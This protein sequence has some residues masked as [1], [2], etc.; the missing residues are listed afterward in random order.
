M[1]AVAQQSVVQESHT[2]ATLAAE[3]SEAEPGSTV[4]IALKH[5]PKEGWHTYWKNPGDSGIQTII[6]W[7]LSDGSTIGETLYPVPHPLPFGPLTNYGYDAPSILLTPITIPS[8]YQAPTYPVKASI[9]WLICEVECIP[10]FGEFSFDI[11]IGENTIS[12]ENRSIFT[13]ARTKM[14]EPAFW[15]ASLSIAPEAAEL[16]VYMD[17]EETS[18]LSDAY[19]FPDQE[20]ILDYAAPQTFRISEDG[21]VLSLTRLKGSV[22]PEAI[23]GILKL[24]IGD[25]VTAVEVDPERHIVESISNTS[26]APIIHASSLPLWQA[27]LF[28]LIGGLILNLM[29]CVFPVLSLKAFSFLSAGGLSKSERRQEGWSYTFGILASFGAVVGV[30]LLLRAGGSAVG[31]G[32]QLQEPMFVAFMIFVMVL[33]S[34]SLAGMFNIQTGFEGAG[35]AL[36]SQSGNK[37][38]FFTGVLATLVAT[39]CTAPFM[40]PA[41][42]YALSQ[43]F[44]VALTVFFMLGFGLALPFL[45]LSYSE[46]VAR[47]MPRP[48]AWMEKFKKGLAFPML[49]TAA[50]LLWVFSNS[51]GS[52][53]MLLLMLALITIVFAIWLWQQSDG[54]VVRVLSPLIGLLAVVAFVTQ[55]ET[56][57]APSGENAPEGFANTAVYSN[58]TLDGL[59]NDDKPVF[60]YFTA[61]WCITC[62]VNERVAL[63]REETIDMF[64]KAGITVLKGDY[65]NQDAEIAGVLS[66]YGRA[67]VPL[68]L[69]FPAGSKE[70][71]VLP[72][73]LTVGLLADTIDG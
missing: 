57:P 62:K 70:A 30:L 14:P 54:K 27:A 24:T 55:I 43:P 5:E 64:D 40:A 2:L 38:A 46:T 63:Y 10:Q 26:D 51:A 21:L 37:G 33:V 56:M 12:A 58:A 65:T 67:G 71:V 18:D 72:E 66:K 52:F 8:E 34:L 39:P 48:G 1:V 25:H 31:W 28:A 16:V 6:N 53:A 4:W 45:V 44:Y 3:K 23:S 41:L 36:A 35:Q 15:D 47:A 17:A 32:F 20:G 42:G 22:A 60:A 11:Q 19:F 7:S 13:E 49:A 69:Y 9:E 61:D 29:P 73:V 50:W 59:L 68:Y